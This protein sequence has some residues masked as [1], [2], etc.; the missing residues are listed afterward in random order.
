[1]IQR[2]YITNYIVRKY[3]LTA[4]FTLTPDYYTYDPIHADTATYDSFVANA[5]YYWLDNYWNTAKKLVY[6]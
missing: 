1:M 4:P 5:N 2:D 3:P 6:S